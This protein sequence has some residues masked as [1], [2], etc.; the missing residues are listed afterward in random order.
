MHLD[1]GVH[2]K[3]MLHNCDILS[4]VILNEPGNAVFTNG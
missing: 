1:L 2:C 3:M 4:Q